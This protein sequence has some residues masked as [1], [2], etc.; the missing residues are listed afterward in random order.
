MDGETL[1][2]RIN[3][4]RAR[5]AAHVGRDVAVYRPVDVSAPLINRL[6]VIPA[7][8]NAADPKYV[9]PNLYGK[10]VWFGDFDGAQTQPGDYLVRLNDGAVWFVAAQQPLLPIVCVSC[11]RKLALLRP[12]KQ[13][14]VGVVGYGGEYP[15]N[16]DTPLGDEGRLWPASVLQGRKS[17]GATALPASVKELLWEIL[18]PVS[19]R[20]RIRAADI[21]VDD[22]R[23]RY[24]V[25]SAESTDLGWR[26]QAESAH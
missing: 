1:E 7:A 12:E 25:Q 2:A 17:Q 19:A 9:K 13:T 5:A 15:A 6:Y 8:F 3:L 22:V 16:L 21:L 4:G 14:A 20:F 23:T 18:L 26:I 10:P 24:I 11:N